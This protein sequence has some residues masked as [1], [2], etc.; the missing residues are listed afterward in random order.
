MRSVSRQVGIWAPPGQRPGDDVLALAAE[1]GALGGARALARWLGAPGVA[2]GSTDAVAYVHGERHDL[3]WEFQLSASFRWQAHIHRMNPAFAAQRLTRL[4]GYFGLTD[5]MTR[6]VESLS[7]GE[8]ARANLAV[9][10]LPQPHLLVWE[11]PFRSL[12][13][14]DW[15]QLCRSV[16][17]LCRTEGL[18]VIMVAEAHETANDMEDITNDW[19][20]QT[21]PDHPGDRH[22]AWAPRGRVAA[23]GTHWP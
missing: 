7:P 21:R 12:P 4:A 16:R 17:R 23:T 6:R 9:A 3:W 11:E 2:P 22:R 18:T 14:P 1:A 10:L 20:H 13:G 5:L 19:L 15:M 8:L